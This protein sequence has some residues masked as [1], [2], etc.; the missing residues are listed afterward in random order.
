MS[1]H[2]YLAGRWE[3]AVELVERSLQTFL[4]IGD[5]M[6]GTIAAIN[7][8]GFLS[9]QG[10]L[11]EAEPLF[12]RS[13]ELRRATG[14]PLKIADGANELGRFAA[15]IGKFDEA[16]TLLTEARELG[17]AEGD[18]I[19]ILT[20]GVWLAECHVLEGDAAA[21]LAVCDESLEL[22]ET[23]SGVSILQSMLHRLRGWSLLQLKDLEAA[24]NAFDESL[25]L[26]R[27]DAENV[28]MRSSDYEVALT[29]DALARLGE[30]V[31]DPTA[32]LEAERNAI[33]AKLAVLKLPKPPLP[34]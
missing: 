3:E 4:K 10:R 20:S 23:V 7:L 22:A 24:A 12:R 17:A 16:R 30:L 31:G 19:E 32:D 26:A 5:E 21:A 33:V 34:F 18:E 11:E 27:L 2:A 8:A 1:Q 25:R 14:N 6:N 9:D 13:L 15:R 29:L 28:L